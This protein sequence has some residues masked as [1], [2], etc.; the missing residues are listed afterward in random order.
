MLVSNHFFK[1]IHNDKLISWF[2]YQR[3]MI[4]ICVDRNCVEVYSYIYTILKGLNGDVILIN[5]RYFWTY[6]WL[7]IPHNLFLVLGSYL[8]IFFSALKRVF[9]YQNTLQDYFSTQM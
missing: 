5:L 8:F 3:K 2:V 4:R 7:Q 6:F 1:F 9:T